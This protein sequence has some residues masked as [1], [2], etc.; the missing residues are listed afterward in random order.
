MAVN[1][2][3]ETDLVSGESCTVLHSAEGVTTGELQGKF[4]PPFAAWE[5]NIDSY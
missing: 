3:I 1:W 4:I 5:F 2:L